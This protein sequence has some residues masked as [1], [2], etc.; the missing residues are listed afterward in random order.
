MKA[1][2]K[3]FETKSEEAKKHFEDQKFEKTTAKEKQRKA[4]DQNKGKIFKAETLK[5][6]DYLDSL[7]DGLKNTSRYDK[8][9]NDRY[10]EFRKLEDKY[11]QL[12]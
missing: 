6:K 11:K 7:D 2:T 1:L 5:I 8:E 9:M 12:M 4:L 10:E 3:S